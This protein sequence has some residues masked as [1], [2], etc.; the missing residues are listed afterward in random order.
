VAEAL[1]GIALP[2]GLLPHV[3]AGDAEVAGGQVARF[4]APDASVSDVAAQLGAELERLGYAVEGADAVTADG[5]RL[6]ATR[7]TTVVTGTVTEDE[8]RVVV[9][10]RV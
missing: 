1:T 8:G 7:E 5:A 9:E 6:R 3:E 4:A 10:L 2:D